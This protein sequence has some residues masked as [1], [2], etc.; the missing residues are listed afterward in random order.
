MD[1]HENP[2]T[3]TVTA[4][5]ELPGLNSE[6]IAIEVQGN[7]LAV[8]G[9]TK[10]LENHEKGTYA[11]QER[12]Y[13]KFSRTVQIPHGIKVSRL[14]QTSYEFP[15]LTIFVSFRLK[16]CRQRWKMECSR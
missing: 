10:R 11:M 5:M 1:L 14:V 15:C 8:S 7:H 16:K 12:S 2:E 3:R 9:E 13:G 4:T 6:D